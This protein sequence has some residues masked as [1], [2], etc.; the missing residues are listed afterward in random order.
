MLPVEA[1]DVA[2]RCV[3]EYARTRA[4]RQSVNPD[5]VCPDR[6]F[7]AVP[8]ERRARA[9]PRH[10][11]SRNDRL[12]NGRAVAASEVNATATVALSS[13]MRGETADASSRS[14]LLSC[15]YNEI[16]PTDNMYAW[17]VD[18]F[19]SIVSF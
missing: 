3:R 9:I 15:G 5:R 17:I 14:V 2:Y 18:D 7:V 8:D 19:D 10:R 1:V 11:D 12:T 16:L 6:P 13:D 4:R